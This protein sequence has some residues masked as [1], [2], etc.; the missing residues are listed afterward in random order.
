MKYG[1]GV[2]CTSKSQYLKLIA[3]AKDLGLTCKLTSS[4]F[5]AYPFIGWWGL[6][7][8]PNITAWKVVAGSIK[9]IGEI[10][11][12]RG[13][14]IVSMKLHDLP[15]RGDD[16]IRVGD[17]VERINGHNGGVNEG[18]RGI[19]SKIH[20]NTTRINVNGKET[21]HFSVNLRKIKAGGPSPTT[22]NQSSNEQVHRSIEG[23]GNGP[24][25]GKAIRSDSCTGRIATA[26]RLVGNRITAATGK[27]RVGH[28]EISH[29]SVLS[30]HL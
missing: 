24:S 13:L 15:E 18:E 10:N 20:E 3:L 7:D 23:T 9:D 6:T 21:S 5:D 14:H 8:G 27:G 30:N 22:N 2:L 12:I 1:E 28:S 11:F 29:T 4:H 26:S 19:V 25:T 16:I 17:T